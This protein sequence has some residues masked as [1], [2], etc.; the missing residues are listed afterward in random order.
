MPKS[1]RK[2]KS[3]VN[4]SYGVEGNSVMKIYFVVFMQKFL[5]I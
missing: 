1:L 2:V 4:L 5:L 3:R